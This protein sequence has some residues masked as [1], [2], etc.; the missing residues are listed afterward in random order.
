MDLAKTVTQRRRHVGLTQRDLADLAGVSERLV[1]QVE[2][3]KRTA[4]FD[5]VEAILTTL[6]IELTAEVRR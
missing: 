2:A 6:G 1:R 5:K 3:G 4:Q